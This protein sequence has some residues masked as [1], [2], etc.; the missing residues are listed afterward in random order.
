MKNISAIY[1]IT[2][3][4]NGKMYVGFTD[5]FQ[6]RKANHLLELSK[7]I[8]RNPHLQGAYNKYGKSS[9]EIEIIEECSINLLVAME[10]YWATILNVH[11][12]DFGYNIAPTNPLTRSSRPMLGKKHTKETKEKISKNRKGKRV[13]IDNPF[14]GKTHSPEIKKIMSEKSL[15]RKVSQEG[16]NNMSKARKGIMPKNIDI[17]KGW[18]KGKHLS[19]ETKKKI[20][21]FQ[22][23]KVYQYSLDGEFIKEW[24]CAQ[25]AAKALGFKS[26]SEIGRCV[27]GDRYSKSAYGYKWKYKKDI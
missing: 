17:I 18:M 4:Q 25:D 11:N 23:T 19:Q 1:T 6:E 12:P 16:R 9:I 26:H 24:N 22:K 21:E 14:F 5:N 10:H 20:S 3:S 7:N 27:R 13:G 15:G 2:N 8:H